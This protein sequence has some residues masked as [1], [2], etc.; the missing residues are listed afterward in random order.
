MSEEELR[1]AIADAV[2]V[3]I[4]KYFDK[5]HVCRIPISDEVAEKIPHV[6]GMIADLDKGNFDQGVEK[7]RQNHLWVDKRRIEKE[8]EYAANHRWVTAW[9]TRSTSIWSKIFEWTILGI[10]GYLALMAGQ[11]FWNQVR[12]HITKAAPK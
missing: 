10:L 3:G 8:E 4:E 6:L 1:K 11:G 12:E 2:V 9:R 7:M 5:H